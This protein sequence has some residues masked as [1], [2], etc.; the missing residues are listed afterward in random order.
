MSRVCGCTHRHIHTHT[1][2]IFSIHSVAD[3]LVGSFH[4]LA[5]VS[6]AA[7]RI[8]VHMS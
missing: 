7:R 6:S 1:C 5:V 3:E 4:F 8:G 2:H